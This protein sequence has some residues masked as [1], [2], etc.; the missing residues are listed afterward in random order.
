MGPIRYPTCFG[1]DIA[2]YAWG[3]LRNGRAS[4]ASLNQLLV[5][6]RSSP[7]SFNR[8]PRSESRGQSELNWTCHLPKQ[9]VPF[10][11]NKGCT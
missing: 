4:S 1:S 7:H 10:G 5:R 9:Q 8:F 2:K 6:D 11:R 3:K